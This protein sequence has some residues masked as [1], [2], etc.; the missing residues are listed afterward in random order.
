MVNRER[1]FSTDK[2]FVIL[3][4]NESVVLSAAY[5]G[6]LELTE[7]FSRCRTLSRVSIA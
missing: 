6:D 7:M 3:R 1:K 2:N 5:L 4:N